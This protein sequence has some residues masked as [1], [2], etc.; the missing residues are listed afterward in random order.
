MPDSPAALETPAL[1]VDLDRM[2]ANIR[3]TADY[4]AR[5]GLRYRP[6]VKTH[7]SSWVASRQLDA[8]AN[9]LTCA[10]P[11]EAEVMRGATDDLL[12]AYPAIGA[13]RIARVGAL[14]AD[15]SLRVMVDSEEAIDAL[16]QAAAIAGRDI[17]VL[18]ELDV[19]MRRVG[20]ATPEDAV[21]LARRVA[22]TTGLRWTGIGCYPG[23]IRTIP[24]DDAPELVA[25]N[26]RLDATIAA[27]GDAGLPPEVVSAGSTPTL[28]HSHLVRG[29]TEIRPGTSVYNDRTTAEIGGCAMDDCALTVLATV[30]SVAVPG[31]AVIDAGTKALGREP[32]RG[33]EAPGFGVVQGRPEVVVTA[34]SEE[35]GMLDLSATAWRPR[36]GDQVRIIPN[37][38]C[39]VV[40]LADVVHGLRG[41]TIERSWRV[42]ARGRDAEALR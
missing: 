16:A 21:R 33:V 6:H 14:A 9:G 38:V 23:H 11:R 42:E 17:G 10:T 29:V 41:E 8:G 18:V 37:H 19:G 31:Q 39:I 40:H 34:M 26:A 25:L 30:I 7:K 2:D 36:I 32:I 1:L 22:D 15:A 3:R 12:L 27:L 13:A 35:H 20:V 4:A 24:R 5:H 28:W